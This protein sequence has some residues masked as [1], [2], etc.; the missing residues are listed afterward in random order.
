MKTWGL[1]RRDWILVLMVGGIVGVYAVI[2]D[3]RGGGD[4]ALPAPGPASPESPAFDEGS[5]G[6]GWGGESAAATRAS[7]GPSGTPAGVTRLRPH[8]VIDRSG[9]GQPVEAVSVLVPDGWRFESRVT[10]KGEGGFCS[11]DHAGVFWDATSPD[12]SAA[13]GSRPAILVSNWP[14]T[15]QGQGVAPTGYCHL[16]EVQSN[17]EFVERVLVPIVSPGNRIVEVEEITDLPAEVRQQA[18]ARSAQDAMIGGRT[19]PSGTAVV[20]R[21]PDGR[22]EEMI[23]VFYFVTEHPAPSPWVPGF[24]MV[25]T[26]TP[27]VVRAPAGAPERAVSMAATI[28]S[29]VRFNP[30]WQRAIQE[31]DRKLTEIAVRGAAERSQILANSFREVGEIQMSGW[32]ERTEADWR[33]AQSVADALAGLDRRVDPHTGREV[34]LDATGTRFFANAA[35]EF[36][37]VDA[38]DLDPRRLFPSEEWREMPS[39]NRPR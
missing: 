17:R 37:V 30:G 8:T 34:R 36:L 27:L 28:L 32:R 1:S 29:T 33:G 20:T 7:G 22:H 10:W 11:G 16:G 21:T 12:G 19:T 31:I 2:D 15:F 23:L 13:V 14:D 3:L 26:T 24:R 6:A 18:Q 39:A 35:G 4:G 5:P 38:P 25:L 9:F